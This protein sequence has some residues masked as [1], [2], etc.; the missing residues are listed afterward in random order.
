MS[1][2]AIQFV[3]YKTRSYL[4]RALKSIAPEV[5]SLPHSCVVAILD[6]N[7]GDDLSDIPRQFPQLPIRIFS[8]PRN[9]GFGDGHND[10]A[11][12]VPAHIRLLLN[13]DIEFIEERTITRLVERLYSDDR[14]AAVGPQL[15]TVQDTP[16]A[17]D[18]GMLPSTN[19]A[20]WFANRIGRSYYMPCERVCDVAWVSGA[21]FCVRDEAL[22]SVG[23]F[24]PAF[25]LYKEEEDLCFRL[26]QAGWRIIYDP[27]IHVRHIG[28]VV[29]S[30][31][32]F[33]SDSQ[34]Y[35]AQ[36]HCS[37]PWRTVAWIL[38]RIGK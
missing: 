22:A 16:Q 12:H 11:R 17:W 27:Q 10:I 7:S 33:M 21:V 8:S 3:N 35:F 28:S 36:K 20:A 14:I 4:L 34:W 26:R 23:G 13:P 18:H 2:I 9:R 24:D 31:D 25:F 32:D 19:R 30:K 5:S 29:A 15:R 6:N 1:T 37:L 38:N